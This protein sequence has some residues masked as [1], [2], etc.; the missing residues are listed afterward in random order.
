MAGGMRHLLPERLHPGGHGRA[1]LLRG[2]EPSSLC[3]VELRIKLVAA[4]IATNFGFLYKSWGRITF[5]EHHGGTTLESTQRI[6]ATIPTVRGR[7]RDRWWSGRSQCAA[8]A[9]PP[10]ARPG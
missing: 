4:W 7:G 5:P 1:G 2:A 6:V 8:W 3:C 9:G 10:A